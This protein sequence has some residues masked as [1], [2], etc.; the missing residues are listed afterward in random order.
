[1]TDWACVEGALPRDTSIP[2]GTASLDSI[3][4]TQEI[5]RRPSRR[6]DYEKENSAL[7]AL[8]VA[9]ADSPSTI[10]QT[11]AD[12]V[13]DVLNADS[14][15][16]SL[17]AKDG[18]RFY[19]AAIAGAWQPHL[20]GGTPRNFGPCGDVLDHNVPMLFS[21]WERRYPYL[22]AA[23]PLA[24]EGL[25]VPFHVDGRAVGTI[26]AIAHSVRRE[27]EAEDLRIL[28]SMGRFASAAYQAVETIERIKLENAARE[29]A[30][31]ELR[32][33]TTTLEAQVLVRTE[34]LRLSENRWRSIFDNSAVG[35]CAATPDGRF[36]MV[37]SAFQRMMGYTEDELL[38]RSFLDIT[39]P[40]FRDLNAALVA[41]L[42]DGR[43]NEF[44][45]EKQCRRKDGSLIW[46]RNNVSR[47][48]G[49]G[50]GPRNLM[51]IV[52]DISERKAA[53]ESLQQSQ[54]RLSRA[55]EIATAAELS[56]AIAHELNQPLSGII[57]NANTC[58][59][60]LDADPPNTHGARETARR[61]IRDG[62][63][64]SEVIGRLRALFNKK[65]VTSE[66]V[67]LNEAAR[68]VIAL[69]L[70]KLR[71]NQ[72]ALRMELAAGLPRLS[73]DRVQ[74]QQVILN[75]VQNATDA[76]G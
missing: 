38:E 51:S 50:R 35:I 16:L 39:H 75:L 76:M 19:W 42:L 24:E 9:L 8:V 54:T 73:G 37:N 34:E 13:L 26:W 31:T 48:P 62:N 56:A 70:N 12:K 71:K 72:V 36:E 17:L 58:L 43:R 67:D 74:L 45:I 59:R 49:I 65:D 52:E 68:E 3:D 47:L 22:G 20:G 6:P 44:S 57:T 5:P 46:V 21:H 27:F 14:A 25:L 7:A 33:L 61:T 11:L 69:L 1:V 64:A 28:Q 53:E 29:K 2:T 15:G 40:E 63:R 30:E 41:D 18:K 10:L 55:A 66:S 23:L 60:M 4:R 32:S